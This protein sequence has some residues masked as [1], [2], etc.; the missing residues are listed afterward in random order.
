MTNVVSF[1]AAR[2]M[3]RPTREPTLQSPDD[4]LAPSRGILLGAGIG[5][6]MW[7]AFWAA[8]L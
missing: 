7:T 5:A 4:P 3:H 8:V 6:V 2:A 1:A